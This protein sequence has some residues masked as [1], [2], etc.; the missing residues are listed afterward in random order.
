MSYDRV[1]LDLDGTVYLGHGAVPGA[2]EAIA[3]LRARG[4]RLAFVTNDPVS[5][6]HRLLRAAGGDR[7]RRRHRTSW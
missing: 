4:I 3:E 7:H 5:R 2:A 1:L 6:P